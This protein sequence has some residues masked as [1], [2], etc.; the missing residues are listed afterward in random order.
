MEVAQ[1]WRAQLCGTC[2]LA[3]E[4]FPGDELT[5]PGLGASTDCLRASVKPGIP[6]HPPDTEFFTVLYQRFKLPRQQTPKLHGRCWRAAGRGREAPA[7]SGH[8]ATLQSCP[9]PVLSL[10]SQQPRRQLHLVVP[11]WQQ[12]P[13]TSHCWLPKPNKWH[14]DKVKLL[15]GN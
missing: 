5:E 13:S 8:T 2:S 9:Q 7:P 15:T 10:R 4:G 3:S 11:G 1:V 14:S 12:H 6:K